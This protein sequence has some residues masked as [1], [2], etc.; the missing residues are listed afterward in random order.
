MSV[1]K[2]SYLK[3][4]LG[5]GLDNVQTVISK[6]KRNECVPGKEYKWDIGHYEKTCSGMNSFRIRM[7]LF[8]IGM[9]SFRIGM[10]SFR[11]DT[12]IWGNEKCQKI[13]LFM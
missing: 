11:M 12:G 10:K 2:Y 4:W 1:Q 8:R 9:N 5:L 13:K 7:N 6:I 3:A